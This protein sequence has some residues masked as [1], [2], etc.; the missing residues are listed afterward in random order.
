MVIFP[1]PRLLF[2]AFF[3]G[4]AINAWSQGSVLELITKAD[5]ELDAGKAEKLYSDILEI[6]PNLPEAFC[7]R[8]IVRSKQEKWATALEDIDQAVALNRSESKYFAQRAYIQVQIAGYARALRDYQHA[9]EL[10]PTR[11]D[12]YSG[13]SYCQHKLGRYEEAEQTAQKG[14]DLDPK[15]PYSYRNRGRARL[16]KGKIEAAESDFNRSIALSHRQ[17]WRLWSDL[18]DAS[19]KKG[20]WKKAKESYEKSLQLKAEY[21]DAL[22]GLQEVNKKMLGIKPPSSTFSGKRVA[23]LIGNSSYRYINDLDGQPINDATQMEIKLKTLGF[24]TTLTKDVT[25]LQLMESLQKFYQQAKDADVVLVFYAGHG[26]EYRGGNYLLPINVHITSDS[27][28]LTSVALN[29]LIDQVQLQNPQYCVFFLDACRTEPPVEPISSR[30]QDAFKEF[31]QVAD[32]LLRGHRGFKVVEVE[33]RVKNCY[34]AMATAPNT[35]AQN[36]PRTNGYFTEGLLK[37]LQK[38][39]RLDDALREVR[40][41]VRAETQKA[42]SLQM[43]EDIDRTSEILIL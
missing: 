16:Q 17:P 36:G 33:N 23:L 14:I 4:T 8:A 1:L 9:I 15:S 21:P 31:K 24:R 38:G 28:D 18:G 25:Y 2:F 13:L 39:K 6:N 32:S 12:Y 34:I 7:G 35:T 26:M 30:V 37:Y 29:S 5:N 10:S 3:I 19:F 20:Q 11:A 42:G 27:L 40:S 43:P 22:V 41:Y